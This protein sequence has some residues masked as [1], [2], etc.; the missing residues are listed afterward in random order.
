MSRNR[1]AGRPAVW[2]RPSTS[3]GTQL[4]TVPE[5]RAR[6]AV[7]SDR[8]AMAS[9]SARGDAT[10]GRAEPYAAAKPMATSTCGTRAFS[11][12][13]SEPNSQNSRTTMSGRQLAMSSMSPGNAAWAS[14]RPNT[15]AITIRLASLR[16]S[17]GRRPKIGPSTSGGTSANGAWSSPVAATADA[18]DAG[19]AT[20][21]SWPAS[22]QALASGTIGPK[23]P[24]PA[25]VEK[26]TRTTGS[27]HAARPTCERRRPASRTH[28]AAVQRTITC[29]GARREGT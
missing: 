10:T 27:S 18:N 9:S 26:S 17:W 3:A 19:A 12:A 22:R 20:L 1:R 4:S 28:G 8:P 21:T 2:S 14:R 7:S 15:S 13:T 11:A 5:A 6:W 16:D 25:V 29:A 23:C 24:A